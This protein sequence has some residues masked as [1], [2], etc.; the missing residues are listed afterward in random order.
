MIKKAFFLLFPCVLILQ[1]NAEA[2]E[3]HPGWFKAPG[4]GKFSAGGW[5]ACSTKQNGSKAESASPDG[6][7]RVVT[8]MAGENEQAVFVESASNLRVALETAE[9]PC[10]GIVRDFEMTIKEH[11]LKLTNVILGRSR[12]NGE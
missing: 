9:W 7:R 10:P 8:L 12:I 1:V 4:N 6:K 5:N 11:S 3:A 2:S